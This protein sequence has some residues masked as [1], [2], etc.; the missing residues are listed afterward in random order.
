M[1]RRKCGGAREQATQVWRVLGGLPELQREV[2]VLSVLEE[3]RG[4]EVASL[5]N[6]PLGTVKS[7][8]RLARIGFKEQWAERYGALDL[9]ILKEVG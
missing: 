2:L 3:R 4:P 7:R 6:I 8:L 9:N 1:I 5:L